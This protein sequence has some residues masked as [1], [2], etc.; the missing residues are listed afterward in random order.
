MADFDKHLQIGVFAGVVIGLLL[1]FLT[2]NWALAG[3]GGGLALVASLFPDVDAQESIPRKYLG[4]LIVLGCLGLAAWVG[5]EF[6]NFTT[7][8]GAWAASVVGL[9]A[10]LAVPLGIGG[11]LVAGLGAA[12]FTGGVIDENT[13]HRG[14]L[15]SPGAGIALGVGA[16]ALLLYST[17]LGARNSAL[18]GGAIVAGHWS[19]IYI[20]DRG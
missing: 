3:I 19:H 7:A 10:D 5:V 8:M 13:K 15:H 9:G 18:V 2:S 20:G 11:L 17:A 14:L 12:Y 4:Y 16:A 6:S 1:G